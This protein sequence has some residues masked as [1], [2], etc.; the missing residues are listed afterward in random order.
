[1]IPE[2]FINDWRQTAPWPRSAMVEQDLII[3]RALVDL[4]RKPEI[5]DA[6]AFRGGT[7]LN[8]LFF[9]PSARYSED[10][11]FVQIRNENIGETLSHIREA[12]DPWLG[13]AK[14]TQKQGSSKL[15]YRFTSADNVPMRLKIEINTVESFSILGFKHQLYSLESPWYSGKAEICTYAI[16]EIMATKLRALYQRRKGRDLFDSWMAIKKLGIDCKKVV[17][18]FQKY[19]ERNKTL[20]TRAQF[21]K[22]L[23]E[24]MSDSSFLN[25]VPPL[26]AENSLNWDIKEAY[27]LVIQ[28]LVFHLGGEGWK[29]NAI[30]ED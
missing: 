28:N 4:Y 12:L 30:S 15:F 26:L 6:L 25:D 11:D 10:L 24:K 16:E 14:W 7:A 17:E 19:N 5:R 29:G 23:Y 27:E 21:E 13:K 2:D 3:S 1:M 8:K 18:I 9:I 20:I 22:N